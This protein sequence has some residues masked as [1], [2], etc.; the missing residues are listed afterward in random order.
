MHAHTHTQYI[1]YTRHTH[2]CVC[3]RTHGCTHT[4]TRRTSCP[5]CRDTP[6]P[7]PGGPAAPPPHAADRRPGCPALR[8]LSP[9]PRRPHRPAC[10]PALDTAM[11]GLP[12]KLG[13]ETAV[14]R[15]VLP[16][17]AGKDIQLSG[18]NCSYCRT[19]RSAPPGVQPCGHLHPAAVGPGDGHVPRHPRQPAPA[20]RP[21]LL[22]PP[23][24]SGGGV[25]VA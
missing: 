8:Q 22:E 24:P 12:L 11:A 21:P 17:T 15:S 19:A 10:L 16:H 7:V 18:Q 23:R 4:R 5:M 25:R 14:V 1:L 6:G 13:S 3:T 2:V 20:P 9:P